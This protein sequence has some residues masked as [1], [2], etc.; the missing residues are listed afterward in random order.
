MSWSER[1]ALAAL[2]IVTAVVLVPAIVL[3]AW[4]RWREARRHRQFKT[5][6]LTAPPLL[7]DFVSDQQA[8]IEAARRLWDAF[9]PHLRIPALPAV[10]A[11]H[12]GAEQPEEAKIISL[13]GRNRPATET[14]AAGESE[15]AS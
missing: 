9:M 4:H 7:E 11:E 5:W 15:G 6:Q 13:Q 3:P 12:P 1:V 10:R 8:E 14:R 2:L